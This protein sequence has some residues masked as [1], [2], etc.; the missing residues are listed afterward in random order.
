MH[1]TQIQIISIIV[2]AVAAVGISSYFVLQ[3]AGEFVKPVKPAAP[4]P[5][6]PLLSQTPTQVDKT[7]Y[8]YANGQKIVSMDAGGI[9]YYITDHLGGT[10]KVYDQDGNLVSEVEYY[11]YG[12]GK[13]ETGEEQNYKY[14]DKEEDD[15]TGL[16]YYG[17]RYYEP[18][19][20]RFTAVDNIKGDIQDPQS[21][22]RYAYVQNN[23][24]MYVDP[25][26]NEIRLDSISEN[27]DDLLFTVSD[28]ARV[29]DVPMSSLNIEVVDYEMDGEKERWIKLD[30][31]ITEEDYRGNAPET[32]ALFKDVIDDE[33]IVVIAA[34][35][36]GY[37]G[38]STLENIQVK[39]GSEEKTISGIIKYS[40][41]NGDVMMDLGK[42]RKSILLPNFI[43][44]A[45]EL[46]HARGY[47]KDDFYGEVAAM[48]AENIASR[49]HGYE[50]RK[51]YY[52]SGYTG[53][54]KA[55]DIIPVAFPRNVANIINGLMS[56]PIY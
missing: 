49:E 15:S 37:T 21:L 23:P 55:D 36:N 11:A 6:H 20:G 24:L 42:N 14:T 39:E 38:F 31:E 54:S 50:E 30:A 17:A 2:L 35:A 46:G 56:V 52:P 48:K 25:T 44:I 12:Q 40:P 18:F 10:N 43:S 29:I 51:Y 16:Y 34:S 33:E 4:E 32:F 45:H 13:L 28:I 8:F 27:I 26:G 5:E 1:L 41:Q 3:P 53:S 9:L 47:I 19:A 7:A 22:N